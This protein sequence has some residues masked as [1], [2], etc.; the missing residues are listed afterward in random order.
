MEV[1]QMVAG[2]QQQ[3]FFGMA[4]VSAIVVPVVTVETRV[5]TSYVAVVSEVV[6]PVVDQPVEVRVEEVVPSPRRSERLRFKLN[7]NN[8]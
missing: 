8:L 5:L 4:V 3:P 1:V 2:E 7:R 6:V